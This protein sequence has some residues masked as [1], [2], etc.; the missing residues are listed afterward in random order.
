[1]GE[2]APAAEL[3]AQDPVLRPSPE[4]V[5]AREVHEDRVPPAARPAEPVAPRPQPTPVPAEPVAP[6][7]ALSA[8]RDNPP[9]QAEPQSPQPSSQDTARQSP[10]TFAPPPLDPPAD[11]REV[12]EVT[13]LV[14]PAGGETE[15]PAPDVDDDT[16]HLVRWLRVANRFEVV[17]I[18]CGVLFVLVGLSYLAWRFL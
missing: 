9:A 12:T 2:P 17:G 6:R 15:V 4:P 1:M 7:P 18:A 13:E 14:T 8:A 3:R 16:H 11:E 10:S 5:S